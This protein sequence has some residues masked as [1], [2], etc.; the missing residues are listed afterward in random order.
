[1]P[2]DHSAPYPLSMLHLLMIS[3]ALAAEPTDL[4]P[5]LRGDVYA[6]YRMS[7]QTGSLVEPVKG[8]EVSVGRLVTQDHRVHVGGSFGVAPIAA[9]TLE[10]PITAKQQIG[11]SDATSMA[12]DPTVGRGSMQGGLPIE[13]DPDTGSGL[14]G[15]WMGVQVAPFSERD[16]TNRGNRASWLLDLSYRTKDAT[17]FYDLSAVE[18]GAGHGASTLR[19]RSSFSKE[20]GQSQPHI[21]ATYSRVGETNATLVGTDGSQIQATVI[22][23]DELLV[24]SGVEV[25][26]FADPISQAEFAVDFRMGFAYQTWGDLP[27]G[28]YLPS[29]LDSSMGSVTTMGEQTRFIGG[30]GIYWRLFEYLKLELASDVS[31]VMPTQLENPYLVQT[32]SNTVRFDT[33]ADLVVMFR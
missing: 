8:E 28:L 4:P 24:M 3:G 27:S 17:N 23:P 22:N 19:I 5:F 32:G 11:W 29:V 12:F 30:I 31:Y 14:S 6:G 21:S 25:H 10:F 26:T 20:L 13:R 18:R 9:L 1:M 33:R 7:Y 15:V 16:F 2:V